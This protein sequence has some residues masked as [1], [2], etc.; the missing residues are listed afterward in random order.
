VAEV[1]GGCGSSSLVGS[2]LP[3]AVKEVG[4]RFGVAVLALGTATRDWAGVVRDVRYTEGPT[5]GESSR[6]MIDNS[7]P[8]VVCGVDG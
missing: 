1:Q 3:A 4:R 2:S 8:D 7:A 6:G 5:K